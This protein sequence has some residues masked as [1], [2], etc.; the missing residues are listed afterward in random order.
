M[1]IFGNKRRK[2]KEVVLVIRW[3]WFE[4]IMTNNQSRCPHVATI[5]QIEEEDYFNAIRVRFVVCWIE[6]I[7]MNFEFSLRNVVNVISMEII[8]GCV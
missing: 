1:E 6:T 2:K 8:C 4:L 3:K 7:E 5:G